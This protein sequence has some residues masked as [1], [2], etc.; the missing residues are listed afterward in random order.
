[1]SLMNLSNFRPLIN[2]MSESQYERHESY[3]R[4]G[5]N[6]GA[7]RRLLNLHLSGGYASTSVNPTLTMA[8]G[9]VA[10]VFV[11]EIIEGARR[12]RRDQRKRR[13]LQSGAQH[14]RPNGNSGTARRDG[15]T[16]DDDNEDEETWGALTPDQL[17]E[18]YRE[19]CQ[20]RSELGA[21]A[22]GRN[23]PEGVVGQM[24]VGGG[25]GG[26]RRMF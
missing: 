25:M 5:F 6:R 16:G 4:S 9:G 18:S 1:M 15:E 13:R 8:F 12:V 24:A 26:K 23:P 20:D 22:R 11:G 19:Y 10:K 7:L 3:R 21:M 17:L 2:A 14:Q